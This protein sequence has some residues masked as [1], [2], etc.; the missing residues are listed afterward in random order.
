MGR[1]GESLREEE[2]LDRDLGTSTS[3]ESRG[4]RVSWVDTT[5]GTGVGGR[6]SV[7]EEESE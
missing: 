2:L 1:G 4:D 6:G 3:C 7:S 5:S